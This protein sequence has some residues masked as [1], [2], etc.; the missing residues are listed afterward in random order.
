MFDLGKSVLA[1]A[2]VALSSLPSLAAT[3]SVTGVTGSWFSP[4]P[5]DVEGL[6]GLG[7]STMAWGTPASANGAKSAYG[8]TG[9]AVGAV[10]TDIAFDLGVFTH[11]NN[12]ILTTP[13]GRSSITSAQL[14]VSINLDLGDGSGAKQIT[15][16]FDF[17]HWETRNR[18]VSG[19][20]CANGGRYGQ[21]INDRGCADRVTLV[22]NDSLSTEFEINGVTYELDI[23]GFLFQGD[24]LSEF[25]TRERATNSAVLRGILR[26]VDT[27]EP[28][29]AP[30]PLPAAGWLLLAG[31]GAL[32]LTRRR[33][34]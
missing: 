14:T 30:I 34:R 22:R 11:F 32:G 12:P 25:W 13:A 1:A 15:T 8:F 18:P 7:T 17:L 5:P 20:I 19:N 28:P 29:P 4:T 10:E 21:G 27:G 3:V 24:L 6:T 9:N 16:V 2:F 26:A 33:R 23:T 31:V